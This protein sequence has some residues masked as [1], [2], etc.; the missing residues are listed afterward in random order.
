MTSNLLLCDPVLEWLEPDDLMRVKQLNK[1][2]SSYVSQKIQSQKH[3]HVR[4]SSLLS[5]KARTTLYESYPEIESLTFEAYHLNSLASYLRPNIQSLHLI[6]PLWI[7]EQ[8]FGPKLSY[9]L[10]NDGDIHRVFD[11]LISYLEKTPETKLN[12]LEISFASKTGIL[13]TYYNAIFCGYDKYGPMYEDLDM[14][15]DTVDVPPLEYFTILE[16]SQIELIEKKVLALVAKRQWKQI[17]LPYH[18]PAAIQIP[19]AILTDVY[20][21]DD[22]IQESLYEYIDYLREAKN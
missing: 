15:K 20:E 16:P 10:I 11:D 12:R 8:R 22:D 14:T 21:Y 6:L 3:F 5:A 9:Y 13:F 1:E 2:C 7:G 18:F 4:Q 17:T 19:Y